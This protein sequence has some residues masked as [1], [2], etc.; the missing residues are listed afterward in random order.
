MKKRGRPAKDDPIR[1]VISVKL[2][3]EDIRKLNQCCEKLK[4]TKG[5]V[6]RKGINLVYDAET[7]E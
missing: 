3:Q 2:S 1:T 7:K 6:I 4:V 5:E